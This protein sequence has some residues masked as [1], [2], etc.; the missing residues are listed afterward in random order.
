MYFIFVEICCK[1]YNIK[2][3]W[4]DFVPDVNRVLNNNRDVS[5]FLQSVLSMSPKGKKF[6]QIVRDITNIEIEII[7]KTNKQTLTCDDFRDHEYLSD[8]ARVALRSQILNEL[9]NNKKLENDEK[10]KLKCG[11]ALP[12]HSDVKI[13]KQAYYVMGLPASGKSGITNIISDKYGAVVLDS[14]Y[15]KRKL[16]EFCDSCGAAITHQESSAIVI[17]DKSVNEPCL[18]TECVKKGYNIVVPKIG[19][20]YK[21]VVDFAESLKEVGYSFHVIL[22][23]LDRKKAVE[24]AFHRYNKNREHRYVQLSLIFDVYA[25]EPTIVYYDLK[26]KYL[27]RYDSFQMIST[28]VEL[29]KPYIILD[30]H[31]DCPLT[32]EDLNIS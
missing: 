15:A 3:V 24:R 8:S 7:R 22:V 19:S 5:A 13:E 1:I 12:L 32:K 9:L 27:D 29:H 21:K 17:G 28:D 26:R 23:R 20:E 11:G 30:S 6:E 18:L 25:N 2:Y 14:D 10:I 4:G 31:G 16:P